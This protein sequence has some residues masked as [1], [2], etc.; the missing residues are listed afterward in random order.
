MGN[1][2]NNAILDQYDKQKSRGQQGFGIFDGLKNN[3]VHSAKEDKILKWLCKYDSNL[4]LMHHRFPTSTI[5]VKRAAHPFSTK[6]YFGKTQYILVHNGSIRNADDL[7]VAHQELGINYYSLLEDLTFNDSE[8]L[9][10]DFALFMEGRQ[11]ELKAAGQ[12]AFVCLKLVKGRLEKMYFARN[13][14]PL[15]MIRTK[16]GISLASELEDGEDIERDTL[17]TWNYKLKRLTTRKLDIPSYIYTGR[18]YASGA[19]TAGS[20]AQRSTYP[21]WQDCN[22]SEVG[23]LDCV[24][25]SQFD[26]DYS[27][28]KNWRDDLQE[29]GGKWNWKDNESRMGSRIGNVLQQ[30]FGEK[31]GIKPDE[32]VIPRKRLLPAGTAPTLETKKRTLNEILSLQEQ[33]RVLEGEL[34]GKVEPITEEEVF[35]EYMS[36]LA[37]VKGHFEQAYWAI[38]VDYERVES[39]PNTIP[40]IRRKQLLEKVMEEIDN[41]PEYVDEESISNVWSK[42]WRG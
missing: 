36:Y 20:Y 40:N 25:H 34:V 6:K 30:R 37:S 12:I 39:L 11:K 28:R 3:M 16:E 23:W 33:Q 1:P 41:D 17:Y 5:N 22:C 14:S 31:Y 24:W 32:P 29:A 19:Y 18:Y 38:E 15:K 4:L 27:L 2:V 13:I 8:A 26:N 21:S 7:F 35:Q 9:L 42:L 10:W